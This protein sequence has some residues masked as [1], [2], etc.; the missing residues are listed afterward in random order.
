MCIAAEQN[1][2]C[3]ADG[4]PEARLGADAA[5][6]ADIDASDFDARLRKSPPEA[7]C[8]KVATAAASGSAEHDGC[9]VGR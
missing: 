6:R 2:P 7:L 5:A 9:H 3:D 4:K 1:W 8:A